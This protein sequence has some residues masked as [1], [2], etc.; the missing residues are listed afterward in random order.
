MQDYDDSGY[1]ID[2]SNIFIE[3]LELIGSLN[4]YIIF[5]VYVLVYSKHRAKYND[6]MVSTWFNFH[7]ILILLIGGVFIFGLFVVL[8]VVV[9]DYLINGNEYFIDFEIIDKI[10]HDRL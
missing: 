8:P 2:D 7:R 3:L 4:F 9:I 10:V 6:A 1:L 5:F